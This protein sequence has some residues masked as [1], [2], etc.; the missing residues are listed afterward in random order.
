M[1]N[2]L[3]SWQEITE[4]GRERNF[5]KTEPDRRKLTISQRRN[6]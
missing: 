5:E 4:L 2:N 6:L 3:T 1:A